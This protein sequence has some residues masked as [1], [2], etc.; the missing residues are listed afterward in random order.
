MKKVMVLMLLCFFVV[1]CATIGE[2]NLKKIDEASEKSLDI[3]F[4][5]ISENEKM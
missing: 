4:D 5:A 1:G 2:E 3:V